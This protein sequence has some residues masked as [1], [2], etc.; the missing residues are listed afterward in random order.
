[1]EVPALTKR[2]GP[3]PSE[4]VRRNVRAEIARAGLNQENVAEQI[5]LSYATFRRRLTGP[6]DWRAGELE[7]IARALRIPLARLTEEPKP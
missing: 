2:H 7:A 5:G 3:P 4:R 6:G 1:M